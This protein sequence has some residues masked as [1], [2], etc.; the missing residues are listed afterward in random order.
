MHHMGSNDICFDPDWEYEPEM[1]MAVL[2]RKLVP[3]THENPC[4]AGEGDCKNDTKN[5]AE[6]LHCAFRAD[7]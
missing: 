6:G 2:R 1:K 5:C 3:C 4:D 7:E